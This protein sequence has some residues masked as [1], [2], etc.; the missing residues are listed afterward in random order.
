MQATQYR[1]L[2]AAMAL[3]QFTSRELAIRADANTNAVKAWLDRRKND[4]VEQT[5]E[6]RAS[7]PGG[8][9][10]SR[11]WRIRKKAIPEITALLDGL[12]TELRH[13]LQD[14]DQIQ[15]ALND[16]EAR[17]RTRRY[18][19]RAARARDEETRT[20]EL[21]KANRWLTHELRIQGQLLH[22]D[23]PIAGPIAAETASLQ[24][25][26]CG[27]ESR[28]DRLRFDRRVDTLDKITRW[29]TDSLDECFLV[30]QSHQSV[31]FDPM[32]INRD[33]P[34]APQLM[35]MLATVKDLA[36]IPKDRFILGFLMS[37]RSVKT[38]RARET[39]CDVLVEIGFETVANCLREQFTSSDHR[40]AIP[41]LFRVLAGLCAFPRVVAEEPVGRWLEGLAYSSV[42]TDYVVPLYVYLIDHRPNMV[43]SRIL[44]EKSAA[45]NRFETL[46]EAPDRQLNALYDELQPEV[47]RVFD[48]VKQWR[49]RFSGE[50]CGIRTKPSIASNIG[51]SQIFLRRLTD[52]ELPVRLPTY[53]HGSD[54]F[55][56]TRRDD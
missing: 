23:L 15:A 52:A 27:F 56:G 49:Y 20:A 11:I 35:G 50:V 44:E 16:P 18:L 42:L 2:A 9:R 37:L 32:V 25:A 30:Q 22:S 3:R 51:S 31:P 4:L 5:D 7:G 43:R 45:L 26:V 34:L 40:G 38:R 21:E 36:G 28:V 24:R 47:R 17:D 33:K 1:I 6:Q 13:G 53:S 14:S 8:G 46:R 41:T 55:Q 29:L 19:R 39:I 12:W 10:P 48:Q 54:V